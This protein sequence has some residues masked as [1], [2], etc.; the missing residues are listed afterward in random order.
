MNP[1]LRV[2]ALAAACAVAAGC[3]STTVVGT[4]SPGEAAK[5]A[6]ALQSFLLSP[7][8][9]NAA[10]G[11]AD[12]SPGTTQSTLVDDGGRT[13]PAQ[14]LAA[15][16]V[17]QEQVYDGT[18]WTAVRIQSLHEAVDDFEHLAH[19]AVVEY[20]SAAQASAF[21][22]ASAGTWKACAQGGRFTYSP[23]DQEPDVVW[24]AGPVHEQNMTLTMATPQQDGDDWACQRALTAATN[25]VA[26]VMTC[27]YLADDPAAATIVRQIAD[28][29]SGQ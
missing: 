10:M 27:S 26:D 4:G 25:I 18:E 24:L 13:K 11:A 19:Q 14:C 7:D 6:R 17:G 15:G 5:E 9:V 29:I 8:E 22:T 20:P 1:L 3:S 2:V 21:I 12:M 16:S 23:G 28:R